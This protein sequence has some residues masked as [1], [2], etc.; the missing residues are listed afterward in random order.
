MVFQNH[1][2]GPCLEGQVLNFYEKLDFG[3]IFDFLD[4]QKGNVWTTVSQNDALKF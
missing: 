3:A 4:F 2:P 1:S